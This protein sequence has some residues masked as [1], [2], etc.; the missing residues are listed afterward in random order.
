M[1]KLPKSVTKKYLSENIAVKIGGQ[2][3]VKVE[4]TQGIWLT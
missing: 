2:I 1:K 3:L 4:R